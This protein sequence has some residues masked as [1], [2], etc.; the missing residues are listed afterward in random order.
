MNLALESCGWCTTTADLNK[1]WNTL[2]SPSFDATGS[3]RGG[4]CFTVSSSGGIGKAV[5]SSAGP[6]YAGMRFKLSGAVAAN[7]DLIRF[8]ESGVLHLTVQVT[9]T[10]QLQVT[11]GGVTVLGSP[12]APNLVQAGVYVFIEL[13]GTIHDSTGSATVRL[14]GA[15]LITVTN[16]DTR[17]G[18]TGVVDD[19]RFLGGISGSKAHDYYINDST[20]A[21]NN[22]FAG[23]RRVDYLPPNAAGNYSQWTPSAGS[24][25][26]NVD[27]TDPDDDTTYNETDVA[28]E[29]DSYQHAALSSLVVEDINSV[30]MHCIVRKNDAGSRTLRHG[31][32]SNT[33]EEVS[34]F[35]ALATGF[36]YRQREYGLDP[37]TSA[38]W[39]K[40]NVDALESLVEVGNP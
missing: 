20:T 17:N 14:N 12:S 37:H 40:A 28:N 33:T 25:F 29:K 1:K 27:D 4:P 30:I 6:Y 7:A 32:R 23:D 18:G 15:D 11:R 31:V 38:A 34:S 26:Q 35:I 9:P 13:G 22:T 36:E 16:Q 24:N 39:T 3:A 2:A 8:Q 21:Q 10:G 5:P 19:I